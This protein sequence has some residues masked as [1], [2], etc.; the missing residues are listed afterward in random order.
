MTKA[1]VVEDNSLNMQLAVD[2]LKSIGFIVEGAADGDEAIRKTE[3]DTFDII[4][5]DIELPRMG[6]IEVLEKIKRKDAYKD[7]TA[8]A[9]T[10]YAMKGDRERFLSAGFD[11]YIPKPL[12]VPDFIR[13]MDKYRK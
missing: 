11:D 4:L 6:G 2:I 8:I 10:A 5:M 3:T 7:I 12:D 1:L 9:L 13:K